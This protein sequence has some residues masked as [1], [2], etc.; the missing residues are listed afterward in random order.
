MTDD[1]NT[2]GAAY[3]NP[4]DPIAALRAAI[5]AIAMEDMVRKANLIKNG[6]PPSVLK[7]AEIKVSPR[8]YHR[9]FRR[10]I[11]SS[12]VFGPGV[13]VGRETFMGMRITQDERG[14][15]YDVAFLNSKGEPLVIG[16]FNAD[17]NLAFVD[18]TRA[19]P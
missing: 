13:P 16:M 4:G 1:Q 11:E 19:V 17:G 3:S 10:L 15:G 14:L 12:P 2:T 9:L 7:A 6:W 8:A 5:D 18:L